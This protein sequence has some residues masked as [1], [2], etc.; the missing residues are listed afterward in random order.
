MLLV[1]DIKKISALARLKLSEAEV[2]QYRR[3]LDSIVSYIDQ[4]GKA[5]I[6]AQSAKMN[7]NTSG[8]RPDKASAWSTEERDVALGQF[9]DKQGCQLKV[10]RILV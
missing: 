2:K 3:E 6:P 10:P 8:L 7:S 1:S 5:K 4:L 9:P